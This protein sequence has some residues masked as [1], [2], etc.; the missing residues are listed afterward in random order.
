MP[1][2]KFELLNAYL[3]GELNARQRRKFE[4]HLETCEECQTELEAL[5]ALSGTLA[6][7][8][9]P[10]FPTPDQLA[11]N[12]SLQL[13]R[14]PQQDAETRSFFN[15]NWWL[16]PVGLLSAWASLSM[17]SLAGELF[18]TASSFGLIGNIFLFDSP[19]TSTAAFLGRFGL[20]DPSILSWLVP[21]EAFMRQFVF[22]IVWQ[23]AL[24]MLYLSWIALWW[25]RENSPEPDPQFG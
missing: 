12:V 19:P 13:P 25:A 7:V 6:E 8:P 15:Q 21:S 4:A 17:I 3:D 23:L 18:E 2:H 24:A 10:E 1:D 20:L 11:A 14:T 22:N 5:D 16:V 9:L